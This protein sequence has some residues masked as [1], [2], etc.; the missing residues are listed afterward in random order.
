MHVKA[1]LFRLLLPLALPALFAAAL[2]GCSDDADGE[3]FSFERQ[4]QGFK[5]ET[6][7]SGDSIHWVLVWETPSDPERLK[8]YHL[9]AI[10]AE[11]T[12]ET[13]AFV[14]R[15]TGFSGD[16]DESRLPAGIRHWSVAPDSGATRERWRIPDDAHAEARSLS[17]G[18]VR[19]LLWAEYSDSRRP[20]NRISTRV[21][22]RDVFP[23]EPVTVEVTAF[24]DSAL[25]S[26]NRPFD[27][28]DNLEPNRSG[29]IFGYRLELSAL[30][31]D[32]AGRRPFFA[33]REGADSSALLVDRTIVSAG[34]GT[35]LDEGAVE[36]RAPTDEAVSVVVLDGKSWKGTSPDDERF[37]VSVRNLRPGQGYRARVTPFDSLGVTRDLDDNPMET[38]P[39]DFVTT[40]STKPVFNA[41]PT[42]SPTDRIGTYLL[43]FRPATDRQTGIARYE[44]ERVDADTLEGR[45]DTVAWS[46]LVDT[47]ELEGGRHYV[48]LGNLVPGVVV[49]LGLAA[50][51][52]SGHL[53]DRVDTVFSL[54][55]KSALACPAG[56]VA[57]AGDGS[58]G[59]FCMERF[60]HRDGDRFVTQV[61]WD[62][63]RE[64]C[65]ALGDGSWEADLCSE[66]QWT[67]AC[68]EGTERKWGLLA[69]DEEELAR[70]LPLEC[71]VGSG[72][73]S[74][75]LSASLR[76]LA[77]TTGDGV[78]DLPGHFQEWVVGP[79]TDSVRIKGGSWMRPNGSDQ[80]TIQSLAMCSSRSKGLWKRPRFA[81]KG[82]H[83]T[84]FVFF[85][86]SVRYAV[87]PKD[88]VMKRRVS[89]TLLWSPGDSV[90]AFA[91]YA[92]DSS[93]LLGADTL[94]HFPTRAGWVEANANG[95][96]YR[97]E[98]GP[99]AAFVYG[100][101]NVFP[102]AMY[103]HRSV[104]FRCCAR[105]K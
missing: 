95:L 13:A 61:R 67:R 76:S 72:D 103:Q 20:G 19:W 47:L 51:D 43:G 93:T 86:D 65:K 49:S 84:L 24:A 62:E 31:T 57:V 89:D 60:E 70:L 78:R 11:E 5:A 16:V 80:T 58:S 56:M 27:L 40:D 17:L 98:G 64:A 10:L 1:R 55:P 44:F 15:Q 99:R 6:D 53:S 9:W 38:R 74:L 32:F 87:D 25:L 26:W 30:T 4:P 85:G 3:E 71:G 7:G 21:Y 105:A 97:A 63:A 66:A 75:S 69:E 92:S 14:S 23:P 59:D 48:A 45:A 2:S 46:V 41:S 50:R 82:N 73:S 8:A 36:K 100:E 18:A 104:G 77:C 90:Q 94:Q 81:L 39:A 102:G 101:R 22:Y 96:V 42:L 33:L 79:E 34:N 29:R 37:V 12:E 68:T 28:A 88:T 91:V 35:P 83:D 54:P 52:S